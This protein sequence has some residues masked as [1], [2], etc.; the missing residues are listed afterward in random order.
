MPAHVFAKRP[1][2]CMALKPGIIWVRCVTCGRPHPEYLGP[3]HRDEKESEI[4]FLRGA[5]QRL[6]AIVHEQNQKKNQKKSSSRQSR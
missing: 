6:G 1:K 4:E 2:F 5:L 3:R